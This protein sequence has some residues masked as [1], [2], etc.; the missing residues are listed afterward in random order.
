M[1]PIVLTAV[2]L[3]VLGLWIFLVAVR[4]RTKRGLA[5]GGTEALDNVTLLSARHSLVGRPDRIVRQGNTYIPGEWK[6]AKWVSRGHEIQLGTYFLLIEERYG[7]RP[8]FGFV[9]LGDGSRM[10]LANTAPSGPRWCRSRPRFRN[11]GQGSGR[12]SL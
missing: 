12:S 1:N 11:T 3:A 10:P 4:A 9:V 7:V 8:P 6:S 5:S 2:G